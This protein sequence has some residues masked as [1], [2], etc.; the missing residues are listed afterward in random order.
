MITLGYIC[1]S[2]ILELKSTS[3]FNS[4]DTDYWIGPP[5]YQLHFHKQCVRISKFDSNTFFLAGIQ[6]NVY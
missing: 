1:S 2:G 6:C 4:Q 3:K 5:K